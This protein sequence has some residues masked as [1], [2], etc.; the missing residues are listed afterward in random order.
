MEQSSLQAFNLGPITAHTSLQEKLYLP[1][2]I[3]VRKLEITCFNMSN[4]S[5][6]EK[7]REERIRR[8]LADFTGQ[9]FNNKSLAIQV[10]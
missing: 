3:R 8:G 6:G 10:I 9:V 7:L 1:T 4:Q 5:I 2:I